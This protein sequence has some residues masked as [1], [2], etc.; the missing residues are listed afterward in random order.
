MIVDKNLL[1]L[2]E[3]INILEDNGLY[4]EADKLNQVFV[5]Y[6][7]KKKYDVISFPGHL[8]NLTQFAEYVKVPKEVIFEMNPEAYDQGVIVG[9]MIA[10]PV[11]T[12]DPSKN[13]MR[14]PPKDTK[15]LEQRGKELIER[16]RRE[17]LKKP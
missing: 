17:K 13:L 2:H 6:S 9:Q 1:N 7:Q 4:K 11:G 5:K 10:V 12:K 8:K 15:T 3:V 14:V 16:K